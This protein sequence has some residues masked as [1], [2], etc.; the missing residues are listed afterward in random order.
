MIDVPLSK[1]VDL[2]PVFPSRRSNPYYLTACQYVENAYLSYSD[3]ALRTYY[4]YF[5]PEN[6]AELLC[7]SSKRLKGLAPKEASLP[8]IG[9]SAPIEKAKR[10]TRAVRHGKSWRVPLGAEDGD[11]SIG[12]MSK[13]KGEL[14]F[15]RLTDVVKSVLDNGY[16]PDSLKDHI[17][18]N[19]FRLGN[20]WAIRITSGAHRIPALMA[21]GYKSIPVVIRD[22]A[23]VICINDACIWPGV[24]CGDFSEAEAIGLYER[25]FYGRDPDWLSQLIESSDY[26]EILKKFEAHIPQVIR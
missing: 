19:I 20:D 17:H 5:I 9:T 14:E 11:Y 10:D 13:E 1:T 21:L 16:Q 26:Y 25:V 7:S 4:S 8:W 22:P 18:G 15:R 3:S 6:A 24:V 23:R 2:D 12:P